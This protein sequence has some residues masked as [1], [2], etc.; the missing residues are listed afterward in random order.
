MVF[1]LRFRDFSLSEM[2]E[3]YPLDYSNVQFL[4][5]SHQKVCNVMNPYATNLYFF[6]LDRINVYR[7]TTVYRHND[8]VR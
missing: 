6:Q 3:L 5:V 1:D 7:Q 8:A 2:F 4:I